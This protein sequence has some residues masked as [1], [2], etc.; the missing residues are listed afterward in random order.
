MDVALL[1]NMVVAHINLGEFDTAVSLGSRILETHGDE[2]AIWSIHADALQRAGQVDEAISALNRVKELDASY[3]NV[4][5][6]QG[7]WLLQ[8]GRIE[9]AIPVLREAVTRGEQSVDAV[10]DL[11]FANAYQKGVQPNDWGYAIRVIRLAKEFEVS[12]L[13][14]QKLNFWLGYS[15]FQAARVQQEPQTLETA[16]A[17]LPRFQ[18][19][20]RMIQS[21]GEYAQRNNLE[22]NRQELLTATN[23][24]IEIQD[25][26]IRRGR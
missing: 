18:E 20:L 3:P 10:A 25:A 23:T 19:A 22:S 1:R 9:E 2:A 14:G 21:C 15:L 7:N 16:Q 5:A 24:F 4:F 13:T 26:I 17:T 12:D 6:R 8:E 11:V